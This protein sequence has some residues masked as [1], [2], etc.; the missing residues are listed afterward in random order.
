[1]P[2]Q[3]MAFIQNTGEDSVPIQGYRV[4]SALTAQAVVGPLALLAAHHKARIT[5]NIHKIGQP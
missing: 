4:F 5:Q 3:R 2:P 1:M